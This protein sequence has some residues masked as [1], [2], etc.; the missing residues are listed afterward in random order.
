MLDPITA[1][2]YYSVEQS[3]I[4]AHLVYPYNGR[5]VDNNQIWSE[6]FFRR[7][8]FNDNQYNTYKKCID[9][10]C[11]FKVTNCNYA[12]KWIYQG[13]TV[14]DLSPN[15]FKNWYKDRYLDGWVD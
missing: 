15:C 2:L 1:S 13:G 10:K 9:K 11:Y 12:S 8:T 5:R 3:I 14:G 7:D 6:Y 4:G